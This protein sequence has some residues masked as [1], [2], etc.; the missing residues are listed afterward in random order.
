MTEKKESEMLII[1]GFW[2]TP[3]VPEQP[4]V[5]IERWRVIE[6]LE[7][8][9]AGERHIVGYNRYDYEGRV[10]TAIAS[11]DPETRKCVTRSG[12][13]YVLTGRSG[14]D[15]DGDYVWGA[16]CRVNGVDAQVE[17]SEMYEESAP[18]DR[19]V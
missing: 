5:V 14:Y 16:W 2:K 15:P 8:P 12:R 17:V 9:C 13:V 19:Q 1:G 10:S 18:D 3:S 4:E 7:G 11:Y 6:V